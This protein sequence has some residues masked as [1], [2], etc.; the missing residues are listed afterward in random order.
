MSKANPYIIECR[1]V[2]SF[3]LR[4]SRGKWG[5]WQGYK[6]EKARDQALETLQRTKPDYIQFRAGK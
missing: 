3:P 1:F 5:R 4:R 2:S 6:T